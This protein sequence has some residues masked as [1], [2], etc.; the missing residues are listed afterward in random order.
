V[1]ALTYGSEV[2]WYRNVMA[3]GRCQI[4]WH[5]KEYQIEK[6]EPMDPEAAIPLYPRFERRILRSRNTDHFLKMAYQISVEENNE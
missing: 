4:I 5:G 6:I 1:A 2:D 3:A